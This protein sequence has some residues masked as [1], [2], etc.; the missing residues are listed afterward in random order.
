MALILASGAILGFLALDRAHAL[1]LQCHGESKSR[2]KI[3]NRVFNLTQCQ[4]TSP[5]GAAAF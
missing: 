4:W 5:S 2:I 3:K 1:D